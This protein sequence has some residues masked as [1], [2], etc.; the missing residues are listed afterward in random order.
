[1]TIL[2]QL[3]AHAAKRVEE[4]KKIIDLEKMKE[5]ASDLPHE[6][7]RSFSANLKKEGISLICEVKKAS[8][9]KGII[10]PV[11]DY[12]T[13]AKEYEAAGADCMSVLTEP[14]WFLGSDAIF[15]EI[16]GAVE[17]PMIRKDFTVDEYQ[18]YQAKHMGADCV[19]L[20]CA[21]TGPDSLK[22]YLKVC[23]DLGLDAL[24]ETHD[25]AE[26]KM[27]VN[28]GAEIIG[29]NN[30]NLKD[31]SVDFENAARL[32]D[33]IPRECIYVAESGVKGPSD[34]ALLKKIGADAVLMGEVLMRAEDRKAAIKEMR[35]A[36]K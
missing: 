23:R 21:I 11:F 16:R 22:H 3:S 14:K 13:I 12:M 32:R 31:F 35:E 20:I 24:V 25:E 17:I 18:I 2:E 36:C 4:D 10:D 29:V 19:L 34:L 28:A 1:M 6:S 26:I 8:P 15:T 27:A 5:M 9:S 33:M 30:R 7:G